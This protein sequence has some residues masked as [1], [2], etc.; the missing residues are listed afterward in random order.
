MESKRHCHSEFQHDLHSDRQ[1][2]EGSRHTCAI[3]V[4]SEERG[5]KVGSAEEVETATEATA[6]DTVEG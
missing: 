1:R 5:A 4:P 3:K 6:S 2:S